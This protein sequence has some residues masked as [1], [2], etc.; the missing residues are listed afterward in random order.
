MNPQDSNQYDFIMSNPPKSGGP[1]FLR[2]PKGRMLASIGFVAGILILGIVAFSIF[3]SITASKESDV[4]DLVAYQTELARATELGLK[5]AKDPTTR[6]NLVTFRSFVN[7]DLVAAKAYLKNSGIKMTNQQ[8]RAHRNSR[9]ESQL[10]SAAQASKLEETVMEIIDKQANSYRSALRSSIQ[11][12]G[13]KKRRD[14][15][16]TAYKNLTTYYGLD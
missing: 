4:I 6:A 7:T 10:E 5:D 2:S 14:M 16:E 13:N 3:K 8:L 1:A 11:A 9:L 12:G 15:L